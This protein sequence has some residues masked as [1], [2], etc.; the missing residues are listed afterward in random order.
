MQLI[1]TGLGVLIMTGICG[2]SGFFIVADE[3]RGAQAAGTPP[4]SVP[5]GISSRQVD[6][7]PLTLAE[8]FP[9]REI[10]LVEGAEPYRITMTH[11]DT[12]C[13]IATTGTLGAMLQERGCSQVVRAGMTA[14]YGGYEVTAGVFNLADADGA[15]QV[16]R[17]I[18]QVVETGD[19]SF[20]AMAAGAAPGAAP[21][22]EPLAQV[23]WHERGHYLVYCVITRP[24]GAA[25]AADDQYAA[26]IT[27]DLLDSYLAADIIGA[28]TLD[29]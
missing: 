14:P 22:A 7:R 23:G 13:D 29:P 17:Q 12:D 18:R 10:R 3:R 24:D 8:V 25:M 11:I 9:D 21:K 20:A 28:R 4:A 26:R 2:L 19:G 27:V 5:Y 15:E 16:A 1:M 6:P